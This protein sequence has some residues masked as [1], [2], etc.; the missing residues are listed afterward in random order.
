MAAP[1]ISVLMPCFNHG[2]VIGEA[3]H[4][5]LDQT[6][7][8][9]EVIVVDDGSTDSATVDILNNLQASGTTV[10]RTANRGLPAA[11]NFAARHASGTLFCA[12]DA[13]DRLAPTWFEKA[14]AAL[15]AQPD[16]AFVSHW[17]ET[18]GD[19]RWT[20]TPASCD[21][22]ALL[23]RNTVNGAALVRRTP[24]ERVGGYDESMRNGC[25]DWDFWL[26]MV[27][28]GYRGAII[29][30]VLFYYRRSPASMSRMMIEAAAYR[31]PLAALVDRHAGPYTRHLID[32]IVAK[33]SDSLHLQQQISEMER[34]R[35]IVVAPLLRRAREEL[36][37]AEQKVERLRDRQQRNDELTRLR[38]Q[39]AEL[40]K[41]VDGLKAS[42][43]WK[44][45]TP[46]RRLYEALSSRRPPS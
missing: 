23:A 40:Q 28:N 43:S 15:D 27:E 12:L 24:F 22:P 36:R 16:L 39:A 17:L 13:D 2:A 46:L 20:W 42:W 14:V 10:L 29:P 8:D 6:F 45:T 19:E 33:T 30:E 34:E 35:A 38:W 37:A 18:F 7:T 26:R 3:I 25:E 31:K 21:L 41:Q 11:R 44:V 4:S 9:A 5:V 1:R 32:V